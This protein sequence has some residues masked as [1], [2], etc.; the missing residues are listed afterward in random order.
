[1]KHT[2]IRKN[3]PVNLTNI[4]LID[5]LNAALTEEINIYH[6]AHLSLE[7]PLVKSSVSRPITKYELPITFQIQGDID[8]SVI[9]LLDTYEKELSTEEHSLFQSLYIESMNILLGKFI[10][11]LENNGHISGL[12]SCPISLKED[13]INTIINDDNNILQLGMG[14]KLIYNTREF[15]CRILL[16]IKKQRFPEV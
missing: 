12:L 4:N 14:Y 13:I 11:N 3:R 6:Q 10:T 2:H 1:M 7:R 16:N 8:A 15:D 5:S 9:C